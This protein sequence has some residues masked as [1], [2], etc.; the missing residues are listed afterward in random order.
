MILEL[1]NK[2]IEIPERMLDLPLGRYLEVSKII[3]SIPK[4]ETAKY[5]ESVEGSIKLLDLITAFIG[6]EAD[7]ILVTDL[8]EVT[9]KIVDLI[10]DDEEPKHKSHFE[11]N[12][13]KYMT[14]S[15]ENL[16]DIT[17][18]EYISIKVY[19][20]KFKDD[21][22]KYVPHLLAILVRPA[23]EVLDE[24]TGEMRLTMEKFN[25]KDI[26]NL[27]WRAKMFSEK[28]SAR[29]LIFVLIFFLSTKK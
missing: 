3:S 7:D 19:Q 26:D 11:V 17:T 8:E 25:K 14:R 2:K 27:E 28:V 9:K 1:E 24:E 22:F 4:E 6:E 16:N 5:F 18:G 12:G 13:A 15:L 20:E 23:V 10:T 29:D 21:Y